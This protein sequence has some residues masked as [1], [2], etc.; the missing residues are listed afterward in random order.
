M[1]KSEHAQSL[2]CHVNPAQ[3]PNY[4]ILTSCDGWEGLYYRIPNYQSW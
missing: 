3:R 4:I 2:G 1:F